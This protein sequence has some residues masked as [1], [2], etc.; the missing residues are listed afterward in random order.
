MIRALLT[1]V[2]LIGVSVAPAQTVT[3]TA[4]RLLDVATGKYVENPVVRIENGVVTAG[5]GRRAGGGGTPERGDGGRQPGRGAGPDE[6]KRK[7]REKKRPGADWIRGRGGGGIGW[8]G[9][10]PRQS[11][12]TEEEIR[13]AVLAA[14]EKGR[15]VAV[16]A[17][18]TLGILR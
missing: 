9:R 15:D 2:L 13:A 4:K 1:L 14:K 12:Y 17:H 6:M 10:A 18:G 7:G 8:A 5:E 3:V 16:H 11:D